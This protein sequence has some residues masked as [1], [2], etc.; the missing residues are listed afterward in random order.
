ML[1]K[2][3]KFGKEVCN[4]RKKGR[5]FIDLWSWTCACICLHLQKETLGR[6]AEV[7][8]GRDGQQ[9]GRRDGKQ[10]RQ[11]GQDCWSH[12]AW[13]PWK[14]LN[15]KNSVEKR[16]SPKINLGRKKINLCIKLITH[17]ILSSSNSEYCFVDPK[18]D[19]FYMQN[20]LQR[21]KKTVLSYLLLVVMLIFM[22]LKLYV[23]FKINQ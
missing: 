20:N 3:S 23:Y 2:H 11:R 18:C 8:E 19:I 7:N 16:K 1:R 5:G 15:Y 10:G 21:K 22:V 13:Q 4:L 12:V 9:E 17:K 6:L 14:L